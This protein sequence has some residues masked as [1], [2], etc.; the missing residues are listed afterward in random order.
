[1]SRFK[2]IR[3]SPFVGF[4][5]SFVTVGETSEVVSLRVEVKIRTYHFENAVQ[6]ASSLDQPAPWVA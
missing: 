2:H 5:F 6:K 4:E 1:V 3:I